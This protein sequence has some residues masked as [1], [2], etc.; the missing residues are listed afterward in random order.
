MSRPALLAALLAVPLLAGCNLGGPA[1]FGYMAG[2]DGAAI[3]LI[4]RTVTDA[5]VSA[6]MRHECSVVRLDEGLTYCKPFDPPPPPLPYCTRSLANVDCWQDPAALPHPV[7]PEV[8]D[9]P[10]TL[11]PAQEENRTQWLPFM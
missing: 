3:P 11:T 9:G 6:A 10:R 5:L 7:P 8:A 2:I 1:L 4:H